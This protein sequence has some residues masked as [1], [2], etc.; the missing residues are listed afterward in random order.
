MVVE[1]FVDASGD[2]AAR[3][4]ALTVGSPAVTP[5]TLR[6]P[7]GSYRARLAAPGRATVVYP[8]L[9]RR[10]Q[11]TTATIPL[12][13]AAQVPPG[14][15]Y[16][17]A[18]RFLVGAAVE[19]QQRRDFFLAVP[20]HETSTHAYLVATYETTWAEWIQYLEALPPAQRAARLP[21]AAGEHGHNAVDLHEDP[22][23][24]W[25]LGLEPGTVNLSAKLGEPLVYPGRTARRAQDWRRLPVTGVSPGDVRGYAA[26][27]AE[28]TG[29]PVRLC[30]EVEWERAAR[31]ADGRTFPHG[32]RVLPDDVNQEATY[33]HGASATGPDEVGS[34]PASAS[35]FG[36]QDMAGNAFELVA[37]RPGEQFARGGAYAY[38]ILAAR[39]EMRDR[40]AAD[41]RHVSAGLR[42]CA[43][44]PA[45]PIAPSV[46]LHAP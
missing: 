41:L 10:G 30:S 20:L 17:P 28:R 26:F 5:S 7:P 4:D 12:P 24:G 11:A 18:G 16:V 40:F 1:R 2:Q 42:L 27:L 31:G 8:F 33:G 23:S 14:W 3:W 32:Q 34:H 37:S 43:D 45:G 22:A 19:D 36:V 39:T 44:V 13:L 9:L 46:W 21:H 35:P 15:T 25:V 6:L 38:D 29:L